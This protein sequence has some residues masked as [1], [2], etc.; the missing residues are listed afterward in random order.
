MATDLMKSWKLLADSKFS[1][2]PSKLTVDEV[3]QM[4]RE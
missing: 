2:S 3:R 1:G 4:A